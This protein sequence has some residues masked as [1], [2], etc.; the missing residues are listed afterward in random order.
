MTFRILLLFVLISLPLLN[1]YSQDL[2]NYTEG[3]LPLLINSAERIE[4]GIELNGEGNFEDA[5]KEYAYVHPNDTNYVYMQ[6]EKIKTLYNLERYQDVI[7][8]CLKYIDKKTSHRVDFYRLLAQSQAKLGEYD[9]ALATFQKAVEMYPYSP[10]L[11]YNMG[12]FYL[13]NDQYDESENLLQRTINI[14]PYYSN[15]HLLLGNIS[16]LK[17]HRVR[18][19]MGYTYYLCINSTNNKALVLYNNLLNDAVEFEGNLKAEDEELFSELELLVR[20]K[21]AQNNKFKSNIDFE[22]PVAQ[23]TELMIQQVKYKPNT[24]DFWMEFYVPFFE[25][26]NQAGYRDI[27]VYLILLSTNDK[28]V[29]KRLKQGSDDL[30]EMVNIAESFLNEYRANKEIDGTERNRK[31]WFYDNNNLA[32]IGNQINDKI[33][34]DC[35]Y[36]YLNGEKSAEGNF[37][38]G[39]KEGT[40][41]YY[42]NN[43]HLKKTEEYN[44]GEV[45]GR[46]PYYNEKGVISSEAHY[47]D[48]LLNGII[49]TYY[50]CGQLKESWNVINNNKHGNG[51][52]Y[53]ATGIKNVIYNYDSSN[54][55]G[56][57]VVYY[58]NGQV[59]ERYHYNDGLLHGEYK[60][61]YYNGNRNTEGFYHNDS[62]SGEWRGYYNNGSIRFTG[63]YKNNEKIG[64]WNHYDSHNTLILKERFIDSLGITN[65]TNTYDY[66]GRLQKV[67]YGDKTKVLGITNYNEN[68]DVIDQYF[69]KDGDFDFQEYYIDGS[70]RIKGKYKDGQLNGNYI[71]Y[72]N[73][74]N[75]ESEATYDN[76]SLTGPYKYYYERGSKMSEVNYTNGIENGLYKYFYKNGQLKLAGWITDGRQQQLWLSYYPDGK[77]SDADY[78]LNDRLTGES[79]DFDPEGNVYIKYSYEN[80]ILKEFWQYDTTGNVFNH[81]ILDSLNGDYILKYKNGQTRYKTNL[82]CGELAEDQVTYWP[83]GSLMRTTDVAFETQ[84]GKIKTYFSNG[85]TKLEGTYIN[86]RSE[87]K[88][89]WKYKNGSI[90][91]RAYRRNGEV[92]SLNTHYYENGNIQ[93]QCEYIDGIRVG[94]CQYYSPQKEL[95]I[96][97]SYDPTHLISYVYVD[98][99]G[100]KVSANTTG[101]DEIKSYYE[102]GQLATH[103]KYKEQLFDGYQVYY[104]SNGNKLREFHYDKGV[105][106]KES[107]TY[108]EDGSIKSVHPYKNDVLHG[109]VLTY[110]QNGNIK[111][112][113][114]YVNDIQHGE[115]IEYDENGKVIS[116]VY[117]IND[118]PY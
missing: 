12:V 111:S 13:E 47:T 77:I 61:Y 45:N 68:S 23:Q 34:G 14:N 116:N 89:V 74:G 35:I 118:Y 39:L 95:Q 67:V 80:D 36:F 76:G 91:S 103:Q 54:F 100:N 109:T 42:Y 59:N 49:N 87:G 115:T 10:E 53:S 105:S 33:D 102:N 85:A 24:Q 40:W 117:Y 51:V 19:M 114:K 81:S 21:V 66:A 94:D 72:H 112:A 3:E 6:S 104:Y 98:Q 18:A 63:Q 83:D 65:V 108:Y 17:G 57:Y 7:D 88:W 16:I 30:A 9:K 58:L 69:D 96:E 29:S 86:G 27:T 82:K 46:L 11:L 52:L 37:Q 101:D 71:S 70:L 1:S 110:Y 38:K 22:A 107:K 106:I 79:I 32:A 99:N 15:A 55:S 41:K 64:T 8:V 84:N 50:T 25:K 73:N 97:K 31:F 93:S 62:L 28:T 113:K 26:I 44:N 90:D 5:L 78:Y 60:S 2:S 20:S 92:D 4:K 48:D 75:I 56:D 43:G